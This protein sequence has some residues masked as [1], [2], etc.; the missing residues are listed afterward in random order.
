[1]SEIIR[2]FIAI[3]LNK[4]TQ[5]YLAGVQSEL[6]KTEANIKWVKPENIHL[7]LKFLGNITPSQITRIKEILREISQENTEF[8]IELSKV[9]VF[10]KKESPRAIWI[11]ISSNQ[12]KV[13]KIA[14]GLE[15]KLLSTGVPKEK[16]SFHPHITIGRV[17]SNLNRQVL[18]EKLKSLDMPQ[19]SSQ[20]V[21]KL[22]LFK[23][24]LTSNGPIY[25]ILKE[26]SFKA[27]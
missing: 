4:E 13:I 24:T 27:T 10:P 8:S 15:E 7:T 21:N 19:K 5:A 17:K 3:E 12:D 20:S 11:G 22:T 18:V 1:M 23:S 25:Q 9:G 16:K 6:K 2:A 14:E 26:S